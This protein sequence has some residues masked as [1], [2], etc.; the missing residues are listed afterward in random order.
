VLI[1]VLDLFLGMGLNGVHD[2]LRPEG[3]RRLL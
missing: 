1:L 3:P 2:L